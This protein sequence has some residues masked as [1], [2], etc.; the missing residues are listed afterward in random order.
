MR[1]ITSFF[2][3]SKLWMKDLL[4]NAKVLFKTMRRVL[5]FKM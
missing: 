4:G 3:R 5:P 2:L 1:S